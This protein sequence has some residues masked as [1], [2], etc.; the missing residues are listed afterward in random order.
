MKKYFTEYEKY[1]SREFKHSETGENTTL[2]KCF[3][4]QAEK[5]AG[6]IK[7]GSAYTAFKLEG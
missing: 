6:F 3:R 4:I 1:L 2:R 7:G 5:L